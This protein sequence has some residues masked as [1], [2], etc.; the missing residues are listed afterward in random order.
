MAAAN[1]I[2]R[3]RFALTLAHRPVDRAPIDL[4]GTPQTTTTGPEL[5]RRL[6]T[7]LGLAGPAPSRYACFDARL[8]E[9]FD[10]DFRRVG[11]LLDFRTGRE[12]QLSPTEN[13]NC[14]GIRYR[15]SGKYWDI[16]EGPL[17]G[18][19]RDRI[20]AYGLPR[21]D[22]LTT[23]LDAV[24]A[25]ARH[26][27]EDSPYV[28]V[29]EHPVFGVLELACWLCGYEDFMLLL[30]S[31]A[32]AVHLLFDKILAFQKTVSQAYYSRL[33]RYI[34]M[35]TSG[36]DFG[37]QQGPF[38]SPTM[39]RKFVK[40]YI[41]ARFA[42]NRQF[43]DAVQ[44]HHSC[45]AVFDLIP[46]LIDA[47]VQVLNPI[48][49]VAGMAPERLKAAYGDRLTFHGGLDTQ[50]ILPS[51]DPARIRQAV[52]DLLAAM[53]PRETGGYIFAPAHNL[54]DDVAPAAVVAMY[55]A[56]LALQRPA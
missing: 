34:H 3:E 31:D 22:Q 15:F 37:T 35:T 16:V 36:D 49:P 11:A 53:R 21:L 4:G 23:D 32:D 52:A 5:E 55:D 39:F 27:Y 2:Y 43:T 42:F 29:G 40:P 17:R 56:A 46:D 9:R 25:A 13:V 8:V 41:K 50:E 28:V 47:G 33:G 54:Q 24:A 14:Y 6:A 45:G 1:S 19:D 51:N 12:R 26:W 48:Q 20:A 18:A 10:A 38:M 30:A 44:Q 7:H